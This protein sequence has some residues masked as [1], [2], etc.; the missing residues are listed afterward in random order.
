[1]PSHS[2]YIYNSTLH[3][4]LWKPTHHFWKPK[5]DDIC[6]EIMSPIYAGRWLQWNLNIVSW[7][8]S[9]GY[10]TLAEQSSSQCGNISQLLTTTWRAAGNNAFWCRYFIYYVAPLQLLLQINNTRV[11]IYVYM[12]S[13][14]IVEYIH[15]LLQVC[16]NNKE[17]MIWRGSWGLLGGIIM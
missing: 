7:R 12:A 10:I 8:K 16:N 15:I 14:V 4:R 17:V 1:M 6:C 5:T 13:L 2:W 3:I 9:P 11:A